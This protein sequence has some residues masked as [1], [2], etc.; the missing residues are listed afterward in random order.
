MQN[1]GPERAALT[2]NMCAFMLMCTKYTKYSQLPPPPPQC[3]L[4]LYCFAFETG[5]Y[6][7]LPECPWAG[8]RISNSWYVH[9]EAGHTAGESKSV[10]PAWIPQYM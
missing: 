1:S 6:W 3:S 7:K 5:A 8:E 10:L 9:A 2:L 4:R